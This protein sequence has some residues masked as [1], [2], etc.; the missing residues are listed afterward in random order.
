MPPV[1]AVDVWKSRMIEVGVS[2][3]TVFHCRGLL[4]LWSCDPTAR[5]HLYA[6]AQSITADVILSWYSVRP[7]AHLGLWC[8]GHIKRMAVHTRYHEFKIHNPFSN[9]LWL[10]SIIWNFSIIS[11]KMLSFKMV[12]LHWALQ[13][14]CTTVFTHTHTQRHARALLSDT[15]FWPDDNQKS[16]TKNISDFILIQIIL[17]LIEITWCTL[18]EE[19]T[20]ASL[21]NLATCWSILFECLFA[22]HVLYKYWYNNLFTFH[23]QLKNK[24]T[25]MYC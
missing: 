16:Q 8:L 15:N 4:T 3:L 11:N 24:F 20:M 14:G 6:L 22:T 1:I 9:V 10:R 7:V 21:P 17:V 5:L 2:W 23:C 25:K 19:W 13:G 18:Q 12:I